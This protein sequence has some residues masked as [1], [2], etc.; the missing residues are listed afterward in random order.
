MMYVLVYN[1]SLFDDGYLLWL[2]FAYFIFNEST[3]RSIRPSWRPFEEDVIKLLEMN[4]Y[5]SLL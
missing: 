4:P 1:S 3:F 5:E 2:I